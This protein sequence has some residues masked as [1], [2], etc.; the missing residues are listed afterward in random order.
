MWRAASLSVSPRPRTALTTTQKIS[1]NEILC[2]KPGTGLT[3][4]RGWNEN[5]PLAW[6]G[7]AE[8]RLR[9]RLPGD[10][11]QTALRAIHLNYFL[12]EAHFIMACAQIAQGKWQQAR[13][14]MLALNRM[15]PNNRTIAAYFRRAIQPGA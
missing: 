2:N 5:L 11:E 3:K 12:P 14:S 15:Q 1:G 8:A 7:L 9:Q 10:A 4:I 13:E 6:L